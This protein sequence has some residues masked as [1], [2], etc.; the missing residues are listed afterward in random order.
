MTWTTGGNE[1]GSVGS[2]GTGLVLL[3]VVVGLRHLKALILLENL[4]DHQKCD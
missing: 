3:V 4:I 2:Q 1:A